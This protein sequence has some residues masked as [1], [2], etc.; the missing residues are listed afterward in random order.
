MSTLLRSVVI[1][2][3]VAAPF[4]SQAAAPTVSDVLKAS[5][6]SESGYV[7]VGFNYNNR[8]FNAGA[9]SYGGA[10]VDSF[11]LN[12]VGLMLSSTPASGFGATVD[13]LGGRDAGFIP[14]DAGSDIVFK[15]AYVQYGSGAMTLIGGRFATL[16]GSEVIASTGNSNATRSLLFAYQPLT[17]TGVRGAFKAGDMVTLTAGLN[18]SVFGSTNDGNQQK[19]GELSV[20][21]ALADGIGVAL[22]GYKGTE[23][24]PGATNSPTLIDFVGSFQLTKTLGL[25]VNVDYVDL[26]TATNTTVDGFAVYA[27][28]AVSDTL[29]LGARG[30]YVKTDDDVAVARK[31]KELT[32]TAALAAASN[33]DVV[34]DLRFDKDDSFPFVSAYTARPPEDSM[35]TVVVKGIYKF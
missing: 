24:A 23:G 4:A 1:A 15:Q 26:D 16:A 22:T 14:S 6:I 3:A 13:I 10:N 21:L 31:Q 25:A 30:E 12:Q 7:D 32:L 19:T 20:A 17:H 27:N 11:T 35:A 29:R 9:F 8:Q 2:G 34:T 33:F 5:G 18:N 28:L